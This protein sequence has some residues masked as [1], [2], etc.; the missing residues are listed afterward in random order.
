MEMLYQGKSTY[1]P[2][3]KFAVILGNG[4]EVD[5]ERYWFDADGKAYN[6]EALKNLAVKRVLGCGSCTKP[7]FGA[8]TLCGGDCGNVGGVLQ[9]FMKGTRKTM[10]ILSINNDTMGSFIVGMLRKYFAVRKVIKQGDIVEIP[11]DATNDRVF[12]IPDLSEEDKLKDWIFVPME[13]CSPRQI[14]MNLKSYQMIQIG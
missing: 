3:I 14:R 4:C 8:C 7:A 2:S 11:F 6:L 10:P 13:K 9:L 5:G 1:D 12:P